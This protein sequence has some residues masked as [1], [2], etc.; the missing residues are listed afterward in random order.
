MMKPSGIAPSGFLT[1]K[2]LRPR[3]FTTCP[4]SSTTGSGIGVVIR[5]TAAIRGLV[6]SW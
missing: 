1:R 5:I 4:F 3:T 2:H 6:C